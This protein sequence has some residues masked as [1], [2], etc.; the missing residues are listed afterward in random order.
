MPTQTTNHLYT[1]SK[2][3]TALYD[4]TINP[5]NTSGRLILFLHGFKSFKDWGAWPW[6]AQELAQQGHIVVKINFSH[7]GI[8]TNQNEMQDFTDLQAFA[9]N[10]F[11]I[12]AADVGFIIN[13]LYN[14]NLVPQHLLKLQM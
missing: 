13:E 14:N 9:E 10:N 5:E 6:L 11:T 8:G 7:N 1:G 4:L 3:K 2:N 12:Q